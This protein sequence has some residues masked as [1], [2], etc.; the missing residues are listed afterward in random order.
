MSKATREVRRGSKF[1]PLAE[2]FQST[3]GPRAKAKKIRKVVLK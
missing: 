3:F 1:I 2:K